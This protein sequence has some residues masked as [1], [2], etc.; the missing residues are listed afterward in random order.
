MREVGSP[1]WRWSLLFRDWLRAEPA[2]AQE[3][4]EVKRRLAD[5]HGSS[6]SEYAEAKAPWL[7]EIWPRMQSFAQRTGWSD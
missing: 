5:A 3:Y 6:T 2:A 1:G 7:N 4:V